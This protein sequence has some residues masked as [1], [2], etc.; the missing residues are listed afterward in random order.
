MLSTR[1]C[2][3]RNA[4]CSQSRASWTDKVVSWCFWTRGAHTLVHSPRHARCHAGTVFPKN[5]PDAPP[6][7]G[8]SLAHLR[9]RDA[10]VRYRA[11]DATQMI[12][13]ERANEEVIHRVGG[14]VRVT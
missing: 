3:D 11:T 5:T 12:N 10:R 8:G 7:C 4:R 14:Q 13:H 6:V 2:G 9:L 1:G